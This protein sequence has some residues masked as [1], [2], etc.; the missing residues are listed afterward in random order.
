M[1]HTKTTCVL[2]NGLINTQYRFVQRVD[3]I[4]FYIYLTDIAHYPINSYFGKSN[5]T[6]RYFEN[7][8]FL[9]T[10]RIFIYKSRII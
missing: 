2:R 6:G 1:Q 3:K 9:G 10:S 8:V 4:K 5:F 7:A